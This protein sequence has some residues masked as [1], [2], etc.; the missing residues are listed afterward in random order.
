MKITVVLPQNDHPDHSYLRISVLDKR[1]SYSH[2]SSDGAYPEHQQFCRPK[3]II[4]SC[5]ELAINRTGCNFL[6][7]RSSFKKHFGTPSLSLSLKGMV[8]NLSEKSENER[9][10]ADQ[11]FV[12]RNVFAWNCYHKPLEIRFKD[13][14]LHTFNHNFLQ[15]ARCGIFFPLGISLI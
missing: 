9:A 7:R 5:Y 10:L 13:H 15:L 12:K 14:F 11:K 1:A 8:E 4:S 3:A 6:P 2:L